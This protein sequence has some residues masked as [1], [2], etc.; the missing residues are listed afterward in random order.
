MAIFLFVMLPTV[1]NGVFDKPTGEYK[2]KVNITDECGFNEFNN[3]Y[4][5][6]EEN[7]D[8]TYVIREK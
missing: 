3:A 8:G 1:A 6:I 5:I 2:Y 4:E 7:E